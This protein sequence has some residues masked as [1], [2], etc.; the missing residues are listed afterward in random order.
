[1]TKVK[2]EV[3]IPEGENCKTDNGVNCQFYMESEDG[4]T[5]CSLLDDWTFIEGDISTVPKMKECPSR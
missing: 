4:D 5:G 3:E 1:M 2:L